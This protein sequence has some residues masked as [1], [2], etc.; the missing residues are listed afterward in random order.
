MEAE[1]MSKKHKK[2]KKKNQ[3]NYQEMLFD[4]AGGSSKKRLNKDFNSAIREIEEYQF[5]LQ[6]VAKLHD[7][8]K[9][10]EINKKQRDF[11]MQMEG[12]KAR[13]K[14]AKKWEK[15]GFLD[16]ITV[17]LGESIPVVK[18]IAKLVMI[19]IISFLS[20]DAIKGCVSPEVLDKL[21]TVFHVAMAV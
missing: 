7:K 21:T 16:R 10:K 13:K 19:L 18:T 6:E 8:S 14:M 9:R 5:T 12:V 15:N 20:I 4:M 17:I 3:Y 2:N 1:K 11:Y